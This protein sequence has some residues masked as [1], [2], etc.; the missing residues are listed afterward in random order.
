MLEYNLVLFFSSYLIGLAF[1][2][3]IN[4]IS[5]ISVSFMNIQKYS[6]IAGCTFALVNIFTNAFIKS[7]VSFAFFTIYFYY[8]YHEDFVKSLI[9]STVWLLFVGLID[10]FNLIIFIYLFKTN[11]YALVL[12][13]YIY[14]IYNI[15]LV[16]LLILFSI[17]LN[18]LRLGSIHLLK[19]NIFTNHKFFIIV[20]LI[21]MAISMAFNSF[22]TMHF[23]DNTFFLVINIVL[24]LVYMCI[25]ITYIYTNKMWVSKSSK[26]E[27]VEDE[28]NNLKLYTEIMENLMD[29]LRIFKHDHN[30]LMYTLKGYADEGNITTINSILDAQFSELNKKHMT[31]IQSLSKIKDPGLKGILTIKINKMLEEKLNVDIF[32]LDDINHLEIDIVKFCQ[33]IGIFLD[34]ALE[35]SI[36][37]LEKRIEISMMI[38]NNNLNIIIANSFDN[39]LLDINRINEKGY[40]SK[41]DTRGLGLYSA[42]NIIQFMPS[43]ELVTSIQENLFMQDLTI[44]SNC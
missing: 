19:N 35:S 30:N 10:S 11:V 13:P 40:S 38:Q 9:K 27:Q 20:F 25:V 12:N 39:K 28:Y 29:E 43:L 33:I 2:Y 1:F 21:F 42:Q 5:S 16:I 7:L 14:S 23:V 22:L 18:K 6:I 4:Q 41:G 37:S 24:M 36:N 31:Q 44:N 26:L 34:N 17:L 32:I 15:N 8:L 3:C